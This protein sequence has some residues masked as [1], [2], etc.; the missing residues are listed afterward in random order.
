[1]NILEKIVNKIKVDLVERKKTLSIETLK[2][3]SGLDINSPS[4]YDS[5]NNDYLSLIA[6]IKDTSPSKGKLIKD[7]DVLSLAKNYLNADVN[8]ISVVTEKNFFNGALNNI[9]NIKE[10][11]EY[12]STPILRKD[13]IIDKY[14]IYESKYFNADAILLIASLLDEKTLREFVNISYDLDLDVL[15]EIH[16]EDEL[17][18]AL[19]SGAKIIG[20][21]NRNLNNFEVDLN[22]TL[23]IVDS[24]PDHIIKISESGIYTNKDMQKLRDEGCNAVLIGESIITSP[25]PYNKIIELMNLK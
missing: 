14:Q 25:N 18:K 19:N 2:K 8:A 23:N 4:L 6:E 12:N 15:L 21:N 16:G 5:L 3:N 7:N 22:T 24:I 13:F 20:V 10:L 17:F 11:Y 1:M 9:N